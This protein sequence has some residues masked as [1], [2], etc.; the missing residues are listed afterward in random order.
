MCEISWNEEERFHGTGKT[1]MVKPVQ[2]LS[3]SVLTLYLLSEGS[4]KLQPKGRGKTHV[5][6]PK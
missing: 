1:N 3:A 6:P 4:H 2:S 5:K